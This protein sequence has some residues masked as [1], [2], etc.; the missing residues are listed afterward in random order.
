MKKVTAIM[1]SVLL[2]MGMLVGVSGCSKKTAEQPDKTAP[3]K[4]SSEKVLKVITEAGF[5][6]FE[7]K[8]QDEF[9]GFDMDLIRA[10]GEA[11]G[12]KVEITHMGFE[13]L[14]PS[15]QS[16]KADCAIAAMSIN[17]KRKKSVD[18]STPYFKAGLIIAVPT[19]TQGITK[20]DDLKGKKIGCQVGT[21]GADASNSVKAKDPKTEVKVF[22]TIGEAFMEM[23]KGGIDAVVNDWAV[24]TYYINTTGKDKVKMTGDI[25][26]AEDQYGIAVRK[27]NAETLKVINDG[28]EKLKA[29]G[30][31]DKIYKKWFEKK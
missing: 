28:L 24:T 8:D 16:K 29:N 19:N 25:F 27:G 18:F 17:E 13:S 23:N 12:Y 14:I 1:I 20:L 4:T 5:A 30:E 9:V 21:I 22:D 3:E 7:F 15:I 26:S 10:I 2:V 6:P 31:Y 11:E